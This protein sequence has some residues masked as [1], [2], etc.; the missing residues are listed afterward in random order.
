MIERWW[1]RPAGDRRVWTR[2][3]KGTELKQ[4]EAE[5]GFY[6]VNKKIYEDLLKNP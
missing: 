6:T 1:L 2:S 4:Y 5:K 3:K